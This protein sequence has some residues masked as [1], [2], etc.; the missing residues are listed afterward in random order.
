[1]AKD[2]PRAAFVAANA[3]R[4]T[5]KELPPKAVEDLRYFADE[6]QK[7]RPIRRGAVLDWL[8]KNYGMKVGVTQLRRLMEEA[9]VSVWFSA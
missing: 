2:D 3:M 4:Q 5:I 8:Q 1:M 9:G 7:G 6:A